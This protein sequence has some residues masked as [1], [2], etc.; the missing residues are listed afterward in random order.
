MEN[1][2]NET[3]PCLGV[4]K[5][6]DI[7]RYGEVFLCKKKVISFKEKNNLQKSGYINAGVFLFNSK[8]FHNYSSKKIFSLEKEFLPKLV[9]DGELNAMKLETNFIDIGIPEDYNRFCNWI[10]QKKTGIL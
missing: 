7:S 8:D 10:R 1:L 3:P 4:I 6:K 5:V 9:K 2:W